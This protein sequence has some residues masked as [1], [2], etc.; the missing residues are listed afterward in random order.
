MKYIKKLIIATEGSLSDEGGKPRVLD[1][2][3]TKGHNLS[4]NKKKKIEDKK[5]R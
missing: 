5:K 4:Y 3:V 2:F 1:P